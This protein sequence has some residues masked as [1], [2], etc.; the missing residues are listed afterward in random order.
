MNSGLV[1]KPMSSIIR[2]T[3]SDAA[4]DVEEVIAEV[5]AN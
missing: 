3:M 5:L 1:A 4:R 2:T